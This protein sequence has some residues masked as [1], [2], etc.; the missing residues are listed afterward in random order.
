[1]NIGGTSGNGDSSFLPITQP[2][3]RQPPTNPFGMSNNAT[4][5]DSSDEGFVFDFSQPFTT[6]TTTTTAPPSNPTQY[7]DSD[8]DDS[9][10]ANKRAKSASTNVD[11][12]N[13]QAS[14]VKMKARPARYSWEELIS[15]LSYEEAVEFKVTLDCK[16]GKG[17]CS[18]SSTSKTSVKKS[19]AFM[20][21]KTYACCFTSVGC[22]ALI[23]VKQNSEGK[24]SVWE[25]RPEGEALHKYHLTS[26]FDFD[27][28]YR[29]VPMCIQSLITEQDVQGMP[30]VLCSRLSK[31][32]GITPDKKLSKSLQTLITTLRENLSKEK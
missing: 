18:M 21:I 15:N 4:N 19:S 3:E 10:K 5:G 27:Q 12:P 8:S 30:K 14:T 17:G 28:S 16:L 24:W 22:R 9:T 25:G 29:G 20:T 32:F 11:T 31:I 6:T 13:S 1:M 7:S 26:D 2:P 23:Q